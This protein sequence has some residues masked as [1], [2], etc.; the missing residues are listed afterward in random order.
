MRTVR[1]G[2]A[3]LLLVAAVLGLQALAFAAIADGP[4]SVAAWLRLV[5]AL[6]A[7]F[8]VVAAVATLGELR[9]PPNGPQAGRFTE[10]PQR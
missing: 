3:L 5:C 8:G 10:G 2:L 9:L 6:V 7:G 1:W 4:A